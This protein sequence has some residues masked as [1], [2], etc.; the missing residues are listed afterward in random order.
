MPSENRMFTVLLWGILALVLVGVSAAY[1]V[2]EATSKPAVSAVAP[3]PDIRI[4]LP[5]FSF[6]E[7]SGQELSR[8]DLLGRVWIADFIFTSC[9]GPCPLMSRHMQRLQ[10]DL[11][12]LKSLRLVSFSVDPER[13]T[14]E[15]LRMYG[16]RYD[17]DPQRWLFLTGPMDRI[18]DLAIKGFKITVEAARENNQIIHDT[19][20]ILVDAAGMIRG[21][22]DSTS[23]E[24]LERLRQDASAL[25]DRGGA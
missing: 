12:D 18:Y 1:V 3:A 25:E 6:T 8:K 16:E 10:T 14:P 5:D 11:A 15:V 13:D 17:A 22:Y 21:Y 20:F 24:A 19:R 9:A 2:S 23:T 7:R 4:A